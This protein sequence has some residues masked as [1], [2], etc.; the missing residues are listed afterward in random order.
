MGCGAATHEEGEVG[1]E[2]FDLQ[3]VHD[4]A[5]HRRRLERVHAPA[6]DLLR[7]MIAHDRA[8]H[9]LAGVA[10]AA[11]GE[12]VAVDRRAVQRRVDPRLALQL[13][14]LQQLRVAG[15]LRRR[16]RHRPPALAELPVQRAVDQHRPP[17][18]DHGVARVDA[19]RVPLAAQALGA[20]LDDGGRQQLPVRQVVRHRVQ[21]GRTGVAVLA[22]LPEDVVPAAEDEQAVGV[23]HEAAG[24][25]GGEGRRVGEVAARARIVGEV[26]DRPRLERRARDEQRRQQGR[27][28]REERRGHA[29]RRRHDPAALGRVGWRAHCVC[30]GQLGASTPASG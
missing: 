22:P 19:A 4:A 3:V 30:P 24:C 1:A 18:H 20:P 27:R 10:A 15:V 14:P 28:R 26:V 17:P 29:Q 23:V 16:P 7:E 11:V 6:R 21:P 13:L 9:L 5:R 12:R 8:D 2:A 25:V